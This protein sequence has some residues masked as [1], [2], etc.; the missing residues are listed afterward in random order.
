MKTDV[1]K[2]IEMLPFNKTR[3][4]AGSRTLVLFNGAQHS[5]KNWHKST[6]RKCH[7]ML[8]GQSVVLPFKFCWLRTVITAAV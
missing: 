7:V 1:S 3:K 2:H 8:K 4:H 5:S 6:P